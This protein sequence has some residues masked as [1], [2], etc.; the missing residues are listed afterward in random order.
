MLTKTRT[1]NELFLLTYMYSSRKFL[2][3]YILISV[4]RW[5]IVSLSEEDWT[6]F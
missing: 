1:D 5:L 4:R 3:L 2:Y 6:K